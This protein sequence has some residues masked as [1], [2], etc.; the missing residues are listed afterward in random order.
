MQEST[1][2]MTDQEAERDPTA[3]ALMRL[4]MALQSGERIESTPAGFRIGRSCELSPSP[5]VI[6]RTLAPYRKAVDRGAVRITAWRYSD[7]LIRF[8]ILT[9][10]LTPWDL[11][12]AH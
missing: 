6:A 11:P 7:S 12:K 5:A 1:T 2:S 3:R 10:N 4:I 8:N 9:V